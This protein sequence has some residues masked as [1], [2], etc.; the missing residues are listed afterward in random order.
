VWET[1]TLQVKQRSSSTSVPSQYAYLRV[2]ESAGNITFGYDPVEDT[3]LQAISAS[4]KTGLVS[5]IQVRLVVQ[6]EA[7]SRMILSSSETVLL[8]P[9]DCVFKPPQHRLRNSMADAWSQT[10]VNYAPIYSRS[11]IL[12]TTLC[13]AA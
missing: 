9:L 12:T 7:D 3:L 10:S 11:G 13:L 5:H 1:S 4:V 8:Q 2:D 6:L